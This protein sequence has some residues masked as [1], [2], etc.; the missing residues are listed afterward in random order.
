MQ[1]ADP[2]IARNEIYPTDIEYLLQWAFGQTGQLPF[3]N[4][5]EK[6]LAFDHGWTAIPRRSSKIYNGSEIALQRAVDHDAQLLIDAVQRLSPDIRQVVKACA[7]SGIRPNW[8]EGIEPVLVARKV[9][10]RKA[11]KK[12]SRRGKKVTGRSHVERVWEPCSP[13]T[14]RIVREIYSAWHAALENI[15]ETAGNYLK[16]HEISGLNAPTAPWETRVP[17]N[18]LASAHFADSLAPAHT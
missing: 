18:T 7:M 12:R 15:S 14:I 8:M 1:L 9:S 16:T 4:A 11:K 10:W 2:V 13:E 5:N 17:E 3:R 6:T